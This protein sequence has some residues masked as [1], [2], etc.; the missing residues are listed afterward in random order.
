MNT[1]PE[2]RQAILE[3]AQEV[4]RTEA[5][6]KAAIAQFSSASSKA[7][8]FREQSDRQGKATDPKSLNQRVLKAIT[9]SPAPVAVKSLA[10]LLKADPKKVRYAIVYHQKKGRVVHAGLEG[11]YTLKGR[12]LNGNGAHAEN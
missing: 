9:D 6:H 2:E 11:Q 1:S 5:A 10:L 4:N 8:A 12:M 3:A 7:V